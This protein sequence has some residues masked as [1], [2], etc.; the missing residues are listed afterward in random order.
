MKTVIVRIKNDRRIVCEKEK[1]PKEELPNA[2][3]MVPNTTKIE[4][5]GNGDGGNSGVQSM[6][7]NSPSRVM[8]TLDVAGVEIKDETKKVEK[9]EDANDDMNKFDI[10][11]IDVDDSLYV[12]S[13]VSYLF[14]NN[15]IVILFYNYFQFITALLKFGVLFNI[16]SSL[17][18]YLFVSVNCT[19]YAFKFSFDLSMAK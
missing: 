11:E 13:K 15:S 3:Q 18:W 9:L 6:Q 1:R 7:E 12:D 14:R 4:N 2:K 17:C 10:V 16:F 19:T 5:V 8:E